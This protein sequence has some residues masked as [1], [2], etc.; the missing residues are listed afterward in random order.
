VDH[1]LRP[2]PLAER[3]LAPDLAR[4]VML[5]F[6]AVANTHYFVR[7]ERYLAGFPLDVPTLDAAVAGVVATLVDG[8]AFP[9]FSLLFGYGVA[10]LARRHLAAG[11]P[12]RQV[13]RLL[14]RRGLWMVPI[15][16]LHC[17]LLYVGDIVAAYGLLSVLFAGAVRW[18]AWVP[19][20]LAGLV[21]ALIAFPGEADPTLED[22]PDQY[23]L[24]PDPVTA[25]LVRATV[26]PMLVPLLTVGLLA[27]F[28][29]GVLAA[30]RRLLEEPERHRGLLAVVAVVGIGAAVAGGLPL[31]LTVAGVLPLG[32]DIGLLDTLHDATG[33]LGGPG[34]AA[35]LALLAARLGQ[36]RGAVTRAVAAVGQRSLTCYL[37]QSVVWTL[38]F[39][40]YTLDLGDDLGV[41]ATAALA[42]GTWLATVG[43]AELMRRRGMRGPAEVLLRRL[44]YG[45]VP[46]NGALVGWVPT[47]APLVGRGQRMRR[48]ISAQS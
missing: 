28:L 22:A 30:R 48:P 9:L 32:P 24:P 46:T 42:A 15:G 39:A 37:C 21:L 45:R 4:G 8:R 10:Q 6:I 35:A 44:T 47:N 43:L 20:T 7:G 38:A 23:L 16:F 18:R 33:Y 12:W 31:G 26:W 19:L 34:Y 41:A 11:A 29:L 5:L 25:V 13:G 3:A 1:R 40:P 17:V 36:R 14:R 27:P 2:T